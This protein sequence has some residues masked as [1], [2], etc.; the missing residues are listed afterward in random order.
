MALALP[1][2]PKCINFERVN[3]SI[4][5]MGKVFSALES[6]GYLLLHDAWNSLAIQPSV[7][8]EFAHTL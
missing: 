8:N 2:P 4:R 5:D 3:L 6:R 7:E 1:N